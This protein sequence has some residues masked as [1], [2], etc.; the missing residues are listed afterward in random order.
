MSTSSSGFGVPGRCAVYSTAITFLHS[1][2]LFT[3]QTLGSITIAPNGAPKSLPPDEFIDIDELVICID[4][5]H[6]LARK[7]GT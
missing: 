6:P 5:T 2:G 7:G 1:L 4:F 3:I